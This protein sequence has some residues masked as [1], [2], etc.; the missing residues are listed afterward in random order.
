MR[1]GWCRNLGYDINIGK[2][3]E[4][5]EV[6]VALDG[7]ELRK[8]DAGTWCPAQRLQ[9]GVVCRAS[10]SEGLARQHATWVDMCGIGVAVEL[11]CPE[12]YS[13]DIVLQT[14]QL[15]ESEVQDCRQHR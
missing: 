6:K 1:H 3:S 9:V 14:F 12:I 15:K 11:R 8:G 4:V 5:A 7:S 10:C 13:H 2:A